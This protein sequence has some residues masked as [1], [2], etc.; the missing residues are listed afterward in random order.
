MSRGRAGREQVSGSPGAAID[1]EL[2][3]PIFGYEL[4]DD[5]GIVRAEAEL[6]WRREKVAVVLA[7]LGTDRVALEGR[8]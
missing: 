3:A 5:R 4:E 2:P 6:A 8:G 1:L 7:D